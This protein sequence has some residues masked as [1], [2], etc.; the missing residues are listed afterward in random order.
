MDIPDE[1]PPVNI[2][3]PNE[4]KPVINA[5]ARSNY[6]YRGYVVPDGYDFQTATHPHEVEAYQSAIAALEILEEFCLD[7]FGTN[8]SLL[9]D[10]E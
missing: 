4:L 3:I 9:V 6:R 10:E 1:L 5:I 2:P 8:L 7:N